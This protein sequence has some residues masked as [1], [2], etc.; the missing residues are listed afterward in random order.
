MGPTISIRTTPTPLAYVF[1]KIFLNL[2]NIFTY[3]LIIFKVLDMYTNILK[4]RLYKYKSICSTIFNLKYKKL[5]N[6][7]N[8]NGT[9]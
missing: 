4:I 5:N 6:G 1:S 9:C 8:V 7:T 3:I 2:F